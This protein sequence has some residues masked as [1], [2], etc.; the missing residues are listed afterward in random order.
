MRTLILTTILLLC[1]GDAL[2]RPILHH[3]LELRLEPATAML[4]VT[5]RIRFASGELD[6]AALAV[7]LHR[8][9]EIQS[10]RYGGAPLA[11]EALRRWRPRD[12]YERPDYAE[13]GAFEVARQHSV[14][15]P[16]GGWPEGE[17][18]LEFV[19]AGAVYD[20]LHAPEVAYGRGFESTSGLIDER[21]AFLSWETFWIPWVGEGRFH[22]RLQTE[23]TDGWQSMSQGRRVVHEVDGELN[24][25][26]WQTE[27]PQELI[28]LVAGP[29]TIREREQAGVN[30]YTYTYAET[31][32]DLCDT[33]L[34]AAGRYLDLY[35]E[36]IGPYG[37]SKWAMVENWWQTGFGMPGF[38]LLGDRVIRLPF[39]VDTSYGHEILH[40][41]WGNGVYVD[42][43]K[44]NWCEGLT[45]YQADYAYKL[46]ESDAAARD[47]RRNSLTGYLD[48]ASSA[49]RDFPLSEFR[50]RSDFGTQAIGYGKCLMVFHMLEERLG[51]EQFEAGLRDLYT[52]FEFQPASWDDIAQIFSEL[53]GEELQGWFDQW[54]KRTGAAK[55]SIRSLER[56]GDK[57]V[58]E[59]GQEGEPFPL[60]VPVTWRDASGDSSA[61]VVLDGTT[62]T[63]SLPGDIVSVAVDPDYH[64]FREV[65]REEIP[66][67]LSQVLGADST[68]VVIGRD[69]PD[70]MRE[71]LRK[72]AQEWSDNQNMLIVDEDDFDAAAA[73][74]RNIFLLGQ[75]PMVDAV[76]DEAAA[77]LG[78]A[79]GEL[80][81]RATGQTLVACFRDPHDADIARAIVLPASPEVA[82]AIGRKIPHYTRYSWLLFE[83]EQNAG[84]GNWTVLSSPLRRSLEESR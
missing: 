18:E 71:A 66:A 67:T 43:D 41:W 13:L 23:L 80:R 31:P 10:V 40:C 53:S 27:A 69:S 6:E 72:V 63:L 22:Y 57:W 76:F 44:G 38:T 25:T 45:A 84:K 28:Y 42:Y 70:A 77:S 46:A 49:T 12:F 32:E 65:F 19:Y 11:V 7:L 83:G 16:E 4:Q 35:G 82:A 73:G 60:E 8:D 17:F 58:L 47:Y 15:A 30:L 48:F 59:I 34:D 81:A 50:E 52:R 26:V 51:S 14:T 56:D 5:D 20:S 36:L 79:P 33:Y 24:R 78:T 39:I 29:Y 54:V 1:A 75:G 61:R 9:L 3:D 74:A 37:F 62:A 68:M 21:G 55:V 64:L 2:A